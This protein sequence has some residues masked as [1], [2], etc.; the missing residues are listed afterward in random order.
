MVTSESVEQLEEGRDEG[1]QSGFLDASMVC[2]ALA[3]RIMRLVMAVISLSRGELSGLSFP[4]YLMPKK[5]AKYG[6][7]IW[8]GKY[9]SVS[10]IPRAKWW[11]SKSL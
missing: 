10:H 1:Q 4:G 2:A 7:G 8:E 11:V 3:S 9:L 5:W 6:V